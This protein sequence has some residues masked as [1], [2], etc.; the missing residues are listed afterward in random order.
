MNIKTN[1]LHIVPTI[2][3]GGVESAAKTF[4]KYSCEKFKFQV[5][6]LE[7]RRKKNIISAY[8]YSFHRIQDICPDIILTSLWKSNVI[9]LIYKFLNLKSKYILFLHDTH[10]KHFVDKFITSLSALFAYE[11]WAD[12][13]ATLE[14]R[15][16]RLY[17]QNNFFSYFKKFKNKRVISLVKEKIRPLN[18][19]RCNYSF[20][21]WGRLDKKKNINNAL[22]IFAK[23]SKL[24]KKS[25]FTIIGPDY[26][27]KKFLYT[28]IDQL[29]LKDS[30]YIYDQMSFSE[31]KKYANLSS[32]FIQLSSYEGLAMSVSESMQLGLVPI[33][34]AV[35]QIRS[36]CR[37]L[38]N[39]LIYKNN[40]NDLIR[41][42]SL[43]ISSPK[44]YSDIRQN[45]INTWKNTTIY[46]KDMISALKDITNLRSKFMI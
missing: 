37:N 1:I 27:E 41:N 38:E 20:I 29:G 9:T 34:T 42:I 10:N 31:I 23:I 40:D 12:S 4:L 33:V 36:Y 18:E 43:L 3:G 44:K 17:F 11:I 21:Y 2:Y 25:S 19:K 45:A 32:F 24:E 6:F 26:G 8:L 14:D 5:V 46:K 28:L 7:N 39:S 16:Q 35:G 15:L 30:V 22:I 13:N